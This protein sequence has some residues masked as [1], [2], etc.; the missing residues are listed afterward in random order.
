M[1]R[2]I[3]RPSP[4]SSHV[5]SS[6]M[7]NRQIFLV[8]LTA[9][10]ATAASILWLDSPAAHLVTKSYGSQGVTIVKHELPDHLLPSVILFT[11]CA[12]AGY[13]LSVKR[14]WKSVTRLLGAIRLSMPLSYAIKDVLQ[15]ILRRQ[16]ARSWIVEPAVPQWFGTGDNFSGSPPGHMTVAT[17]LVFALCREYPRY[18]WAWIAALMELGAT[19]IGNDYHFVGDVTAGAYVGWTSQVTQPMPRQR[20]W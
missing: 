15:S 9:L 6:C 13:W 17:C 1:S 12:L 10:A 2:G 8:S 4:A 18:R 3:T 11:L 16:C 5:S 20:H 7:T 19:L 14:G